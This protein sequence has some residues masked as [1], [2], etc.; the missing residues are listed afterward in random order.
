M[1][2]AVAII[3]G[4]IALQMAG[5]SLAADVNA[6]KT[7]YEAKC[8]SCHGADGKGTVAKDVHFNDAA[9]WKDKKDAD[10]EKTI[11]GGK[12]PKMPAFANVNAA[13]V[14]AYLKTLKK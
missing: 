4:A 3:L 5:A 7:V 9:Y 1:N 2:T 14:V 11:H 6:G 10:L 8:K 12:P 13:D